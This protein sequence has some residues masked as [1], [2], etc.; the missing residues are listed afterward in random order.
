MK[1]TEQNPFLVIICTGATKKA[2]KLLY[3]HL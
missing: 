1:Q 3:D 2:D